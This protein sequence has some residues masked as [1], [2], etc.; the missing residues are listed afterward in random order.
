MFWLVFTFKELKI[1][2]MLSA[3]QK[4]TIML[5]TADILLLIF[6]SSGGKLI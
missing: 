6:E 3:K 2:K 4:A 5:P 1:G